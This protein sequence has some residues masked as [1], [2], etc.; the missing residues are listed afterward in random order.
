MSIPYPEVLEGTPEEEGIRPETLELISDLIETD[1]DNGFTSAQ[2]AVIRNGRLVYENAWGRTNTY[3]PDGSPCTD[4]AF[5]T[6]D[7]LY[8]LASISKM[9]GVNYAL[10][11]LVTDGKADLDAK[12]TD[13]L[14]EE[15]VTETIQTLIDSDGEEKDPDWALS[16]RSSPSGWTAIRILH[17]S[18]RI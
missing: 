4:S 17:G 8:D 18:C 7:T 1:I 2:L 11:K 16:R 12:I 6:T 5:V 9:F 14:G 15:F 10:Q 3:L 13:F